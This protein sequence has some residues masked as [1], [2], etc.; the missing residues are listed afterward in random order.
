MKLQKD[1]SIVFSKRDVEILVR[2]FQNMSRG[3]F[4][5]M[6]SEIST[7]ELI[8]FLSKGGSE[9]RY[10]YMRLFQFEFSHVN[11]LLNLL[12]KSYDKA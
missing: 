8:K 12:C 5:A 7:P 1:N 3:F 11:E 2:V 6:A 4:C 9:P 10:F